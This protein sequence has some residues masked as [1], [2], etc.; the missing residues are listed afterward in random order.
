MCGLCGEI[1]F[2]HRQPDLGAV[3][4]MVDAMEPRGPDSGGVWSQGAVALG[5]R[6]LKIIDLSDASQQPM[7]DAALGLAGVY[8]GAK[9]LTIDV[10]CNAVGASAQL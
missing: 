3:R 6:R 4:T 9:W 8:N 1:R 7:I 5:H 2:D 10:V